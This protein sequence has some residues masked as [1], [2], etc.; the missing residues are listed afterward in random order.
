MEGGS[1]AECC[2]T[3]NYHAQHHST[4]MS[5]PNS[6]KIN[7]CYERFALALVPIRQP[8][9]NAAGELSFDQ[10]WFVVDPLELLQKLVITTE[11]FERDTMNPVE[12]HKAMRFGTTKLSADILSLPTKL[13]EGSDVRW[14]ASND[15]GDYM[16]PEQFRR[17]A[18]TN[19]ACAIA[20]HVSALAATQD[21][22][23]G[24]GTVLRGGTE[25]VRKQCA[26]VAGGIPSSGSSP[27]SS[28][29][30]GSMRSS[31]PSYTIDLDSQASPSTNESSSHGSDTHSSPPSIGAESRISSS[32]TGSGPVVNGS[33]LPSYI[34]SKSGVAS[35]SSVSS[36]VGGDRDTQL[37]FPSENRA[38]SSS[39]GSEISSSAEMKLNG[40]AQ[41]GLRGQEQVANN[42]CPQ[43]L[44]SSIGKDMDKLRKLYKP[45]N[46][47]RQFAVPNLMESSPFVGREL[48][49]HY[50][51]YHDE[52]EHPL[53][54]S[55]HNFG[56]AEWNEN[57]LLRKDPKRASMIREMILMARQYKS[58]DKATK[59]RDS[60]LQV[61]YKL[62]HEVEK[63]HACYPDTA[64][65]MG[66]NLLS[67]SPAEDDNNQSLNAIYEET[68]AKITALI[69][70]TKLLEGPQKLPFVEFMNK[71]LRDHWVAPFPDDTELEQMSIACDTGKK[72]I[73]QWL[74][75]TR[76]RKWRP[77]IK[78]AIEMKRPFAFLKEDSIACWQRDHCRVPAKA[79][80]ATRADVVRSTSAGK[81]L[82]VPRKARSSVQAKSCRG[83]VLPTHLQSFA[84]RDPD[85]E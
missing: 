72:Q 74:I 26:I 4:A 64:D 60:Y 34:G 42:C 33:N 2:H 82:P 15:W 11:T 51:L 9:R 27:K 41:G 6:S 22:V 43:T 21:Y 44:H 48:G 73:K 35:S 20:V 69:D 67:L 53:D 23:S 47:E 17:M 85:E 19:M 76:T 78:A 14:N 57:W 25:G 70:A 71:W 79:T 68:I 81:V 38:A 75:N 50:D 3:I 54:C 16:V 36:S 59:T 77:S 40:K 83:K 61:G 30:S 12:N 32:S 80:A 58:M 5:I 65:K 66:Y 46:E 31:S 1:S 28:T 10:S 55:N 84:K 52:L 24:S 49:Q 39:P 63:I 18:K 37:S 62:F 13:M 56:D 7:P 8:H 45:T 29:S